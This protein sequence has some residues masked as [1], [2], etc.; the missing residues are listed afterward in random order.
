MTS[1]TTI[2]KKTMPPWLWLRPILKK[3]VP[4]SDFQFI[5][6][7][8]K[9]DVTHDYTKKTAPPWLW[10][11]PILKK[12]APPS[13][14]QFIRILKKNYVTHD[15]TKKDSATMTMTWTYFEKDGATKWLPVYSHFEEKKWR[16]HDYGLDLFLKK[17]L[18]PT[19]DFSS[20]SFLESWCLHMQNSTPWRSSRG[21]RQMA[22]QNEVSKT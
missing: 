22:L 5:R 7:L 8:K 20:T 18:A 10:L 11:G 2:Q 3:M 9:N 16:H 17:K 6:I 12:M 19:R 1:P 13:D 21:H 15:Y 14:F 4:P